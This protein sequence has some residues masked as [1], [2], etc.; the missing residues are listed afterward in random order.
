M[1]KD[2]LGGEADA[3][4]ANKDASAGSSGNILAAIFYYDITQEQDEPV[5]VYNRAKAAVEG[6]R[7]WTDDITVYQNGA[8]HVYLSVWQ[9]LIILNW[10]QGNRLERVK[11]GMLNPLAGWQWTLTKR[12][13]ERWVARIKGKHLVKPTVNLEDQ[14]WADKLTPSFCK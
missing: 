3:V 13:Y 11:A 14:K 12:E 1:N 9:G 7:Q 8:G 10:K 2:L 4:R 5:T 6:L